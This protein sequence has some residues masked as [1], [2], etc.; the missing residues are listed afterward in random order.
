M[1]SAFAAATDL[2][3]GRIY[4]WQ[5]VP[6]LLLGLAVSAWL[7]GWGGLGD[8]LLGATGGL[9]FYGWMF[10]LGIMGGGD[11]KWLMALGA[12]GGLHYAQE[13]AILGLLLGGVMALGLLI[14][15]GR[16]VNFARRMMRFLL[17]LFVRELELEMPQVD[18]KFTMPFG[19]PIGIAAVWSAYSHPLLS[20]GF[21]PWP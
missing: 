12:W 18:R 9:F 1:L 17:T 4:N 13:V 21:R 8:S 3:R 10:A 5:T 16:F 11:V 15:T 2:A 19:V 6:A 20:W 7:A 14:V